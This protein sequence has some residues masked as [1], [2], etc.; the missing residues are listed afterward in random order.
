MKW[1]LVHRNVATLVTPPRVQKQ[2][3]KIFTPEQANVFL[4]SIK[5]HRLE[6]L[7][8]TALTLGLRRGELLGLR[9]SDIDFEAR[10]PFLRVNYALQRLDGE[11]QLTEPK[12]EKSRSAL[13]L[14]ARLVAALRSH[15]AYQLEERLALGSK[16]QE[17]GFVFAS[18]IGTPLEPRNL[19]RLFDGLLEKAN[20]SLEENAKLPKIRLHDLRHSCATFLLSQG[21]PMRTVMEILRHSQISLTMNTYA[22]V[23]PEMTQ[24]A[25]GVMDVIFAERR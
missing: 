14:P 12:T 6:A 13:P 4:D 24:A 18:T 5:G 23:M 25:I 21:V 1:S 10:A 2:E 22:H 3:M 7:F 8:V 11:L 19:N 16:W 15:R 9:W 20:D 17:T